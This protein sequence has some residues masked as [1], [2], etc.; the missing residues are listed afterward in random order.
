M[1]KAFRPGDPVKWKSSQGEIT[2]KVK[3]KVTATESVKGHVAKA[4]PDLPEYLV[5]SDETGAIAIHKPAQ[6]KRR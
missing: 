3:K 1:A 5:Q 2:G 6:L 4:T